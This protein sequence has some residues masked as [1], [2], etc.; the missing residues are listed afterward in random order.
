MNAIILSYGPDWLHYPLFEMGDSSI[1]VLTFLK[2]GFWLAFVLVLNVAVRRLIVDRLLA[3][4]RFDQSL[5]FGISRIFGYIFVTLG[6]YVALLIN[7]VNLSSLAVIAGSLG[8]G[9]G[10][11]LQNIVNN[12]VSGLILL[13][14]RPIAIGDRI[15][16]SGVAGRVR[17]INLRSTTVV[18]NDNITIIV[19][20]SER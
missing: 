3:Q 19:P 15:E 14:E 17:A 4:T 18:T 6:F 11:G 13:A 12:F 9:L 20:N 5:R 8:I 16:V 1:T 2:I 10:F 7:G